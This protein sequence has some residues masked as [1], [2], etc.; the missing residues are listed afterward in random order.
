M[1]TM[2]NLKLNDKIICKAH[3]EWGIW[4]ITKTP[5]KREDWYHKKGESGE[6]VLFENELKFWERVK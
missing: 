2:G 5:T 3:P 4:R 6:N 1:I